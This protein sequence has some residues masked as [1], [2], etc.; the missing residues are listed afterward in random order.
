MEKAKIQAVE[1]EQFDEA[2]RIKQAIDRL[3][4]IGMHV[5]QLDDKKRMASMN[6]DY[7]SAKIIK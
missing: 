3:K 5:A 2:K 6:E 1:N 4:S 7:D